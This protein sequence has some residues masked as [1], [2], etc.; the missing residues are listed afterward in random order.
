MD[1]GN[2]L[3]DKHFADQIAQQWCGLAFLLGETLIR[4]RGGDWLVPTLDA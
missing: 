4:L 1:D 3:P 2:E